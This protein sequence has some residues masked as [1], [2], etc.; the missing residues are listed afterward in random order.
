MNPKTPVLVGVSQILNRTFDKESIQEPIDLMI[1][2]TKAAAQDT[3]SGQVLPAI[4]SVRV[5]RGIWRYKQPAGYIADQLGLGDVEKVGTPFGGN[6]VQALVNQTALDLL[7]GEVKVA[8]L[9]GAEVGNTQAK[10]TKMGEALTYR[11]TQG[12]YDKML[13][14]EVP[15]SCDAEKARGVTAPIQMTPL[16]A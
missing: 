15:M 10:L 12:D 13:D 16:A 1:R 2:A 14:E 8:L 7:K 3:G 11:E 6:S 5:V 4:D 9:V